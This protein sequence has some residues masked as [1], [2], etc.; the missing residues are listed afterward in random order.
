MASAGL[1]QMFGKLNNSVRFGNEECAGQMELESMSAENNPRLIHNITEKFNVQHDMHASNTAMKSPSQIIQQEYGE[2]HNLNFADIL[3]SLKQNGIVIL[4]LNK[5]E[6]AESSLKALT[7]KLTVEETPPKAEHLS[8][9]NPVSQNPKLSKKISSKLMRK[10]S[11]NVHPFN[12]TQDNQEGFISH[13]VHASG[14]HRRSSIEI[15]TTEI[16][17]KLHDA[18]TDTKQKLMKSGFARFIS[19]EDVE[20]EDLDQG[21]NA[22][23]LLNALILTIPYQLIGAVGSD[24][25]N[26]LKDEL[27]LCKHH[28][29]SAG[30]NFRDIQ[31]FYREELLCCIYASICG[32]ILSTFYF[33]FKRSHP[34]ETG[35]WKEKARLLIIL[36]FVC[37]GVSLIAL[38]ALSN[39]FVS[40]YFIRSGSICN[41]QI[42]E[43]TGPA[44]F[45]AIVAFLFACYSVF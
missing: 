40:W 2:N 8:N 35:V 9:P 36:L 43:Y 21:V 10:L 17:N 25:F 41:L 12:E 4:T 32:L 3:E 39:T 31:L 1:A 5:A 16:A 30:Y 24:Y 42:S 6:D 13:D 28:T 15:I 45:F 44:M 11:N 33:L 22:M 26:W 27:A 7:S 20:V 38:M 14:E 34:S 37:T 19:T 18:Q 23:A 29:T